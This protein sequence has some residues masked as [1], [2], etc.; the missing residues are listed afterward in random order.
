VLAQ[1]ALSREMEFQ[2]DLVAVSATGSDALI[3]ALHKLAAADQSWS[4]AV[5]FANGEIREGRGVQDLFAVQ[6]RIIE[7]VRA[8]LSDPEYGVVPPIPASS[9]EVHRLFKATLA[10]P[11][12]MWATHPTNSDREDNAKRIYVAAPI[13][14]RSAWTLFKEPEALR[15]RVSAHLSRKANCTI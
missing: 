15:T 7:R 14:E 8:V 5:D 13:D 9:P 2:A 12:K 11:P 10:A 4:R 6:S 3:H 1:R